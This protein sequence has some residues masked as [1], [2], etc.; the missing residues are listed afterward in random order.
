[1][2][3][4]VSYPDRYNF[5]LSVPT[6]YAQ[7]SIDSSRTNIDCYRISPKSIDTLLSRLYT[8]NLSS[9]VRQDH[10]ASPYIWRYADIE[11]AVSRKRYYALC[12]AICAPRGYI[13]RR[14]HYLYRGNA[15]ERSESGLWVART[16]SLDVITSES[17]FDLVQ[18]LA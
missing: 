14:L 2:N 12:L 8:H 7:R 18:S 15:I 11:I 4:I 5:N 6:P 16:D 1:M 17:L 9:N 3:V 10:Y 13:T